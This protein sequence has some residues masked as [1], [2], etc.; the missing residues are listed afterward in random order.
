MRPI[1]MEHTKYAWELQP[2]AMPVI[3]SSGAKSMRGSGATGSQPVDG[4]FLQRLVKVRPLDMRTLPLVKQLPLSAKHA[5]LEP[6]CSRTF[7]LP[8]CN[9]SDRL[10]L[11]QT[12]SEFP[13]S[14]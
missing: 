11:R 14:L 9:S 6:P 2:A 1:E 5:A 13:P 10:R 7:P 8:Q 12:Q 4:Y 3:R